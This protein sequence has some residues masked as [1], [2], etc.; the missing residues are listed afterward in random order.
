MD[1]ASD[2]SLKCSECGAP[3]YIDFSSRIGIKQSNYRVCGNCAVKEREFEC[4]SCGH[5]FVGRA[6]F[7]PP[8]CPLCREKCGAITVALNEP[9]L[10]QTHSS[11]LK[12]AAESDS[13]ATP[14]SPDYQQESGLNHQQAHE[15]LSTPSTTA[16]K[17]QKKTGSK[18]GCI[19]VIIMIV[20]LV[21]A[22]RAC[23]C[24][25]PSVEA[26]GT[27]GE[28]AFTF[29]RPLY[30][31]D[32]Y[33]NEFIIDLYSV[34]KNNSEAS[35]VKVTFVVKDA[36]DK[37]GNKVDELKVGEARYD[38]TEIRKYNDDL[39]FQ[40]AMKGYIRTTLPWQLR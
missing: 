10:T 8:K 17:G 33:L 32:W 18:L 39:L 4:R 22:V 20:G 21:L 28:I 11:D 19:I 25:G 27:P 36:E 24:G 31:A 26:T 35:S 16:T 14:A 29:E 12:P 34:A 1:N 13:T 40:T 6:G 23:V 15:D 2:L 37:Y 9:A 38:L 3:T 5:H 7:S 30:T